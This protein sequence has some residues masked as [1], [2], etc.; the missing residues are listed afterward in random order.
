MI[1]R[2]N[3][4][5]YEIVSR[6][7][8]STI[9]INKC[10]LYIGDNSDRYGRL[11]L[12]KTH[13]SERASRLSAHIFLGLDIDN[14]HEQ[15]N[16]K[17]ICPNKNCWNPDHLYVGNQ[18]QNINDSIINGTHFNS[19]KTHCKNGHEFTEENTIITNYGNINGR[20]CRICQ[21]K[22]KLKSS[23]KLQN[24]RRYEKK[25]KMRIG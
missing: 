24:L 19:S 10:W 20:K 3:Y 2:K 7:W 14:P 21:R 6:L 17:E 25:L 13:K 11:S 4:S 15:S 9:Q 22:M 18:S 1:L 23:R 8:D 5:D 16:H 12:G